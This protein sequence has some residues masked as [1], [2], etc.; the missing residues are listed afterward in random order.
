MASP[1]YLRV[2]SFRQLARSSVQ[3]TCR[4]IFQFA[5]A[6]T[7]VCSLFQ[8]TRAESQTAVTRVTQQSQSD[9]TR[10]RLPV[11]DGN[12]IRFSRLST[13]QGL[14]QTRVLQIVED[15]QGF[16]WLG[17]QY[18]LDRYDGYEY[19]VFVHDPARKNSLNCVYIH[20]LFKDRSG[21]L[22]VGCDSSL[23][24][25]DSLTET[26]AHYQITGAPG[27]T[28][29]AVDQ[30]SQD[31][32]GLLWL[33]TGKG[34]FGLNPNTGQIIHYGHDPSNS[35]SLGSNEVKSTMEDSSGRFWIIAGNNLEEFNRNS[36]RVLQRFRL[37]E[38]VR[39]S[40]LYEDHFGVIWV[41]YVTRGNKS[42]L[43]A[44][45]RATNRLSPYSLYD[46]R[47]GKGIYGGFFA[48]HEDKNKTLWFASFGA[49]LLK[50]DRE[51]KVFI[52]YRNHPGD[53]ESIAEDRVIS[54]CEDHE[55][56]L[57][58]GLHAREPNFFRIEHSPFIP[59]TRNQSNLNSF[60]ETFVNTIYED[61]EGVLWTGTTGALNRIDQPSGQSVSYLPPGQGF[62]NDIIAINEDASGA[63]WI[64]TF[65]GGLSRFDRR[66]G[67]YKTYLNEPGNP[68]SLSDNRVS[69]LFP[70]PDG[71]MW[72]ATWN[73]LDKFD[74][75]TDSFVTYKQDTTS[76]QEAYF[77]IT[78]DRAGFLW[79]GGWGSLKRFDPKTDQF[80]NFPY[81]AGDPNSLSDDESVNSVYIDHSG[82]VWAA[83]YNG[84]NKFNS[85]SGTFT[86]YFVKDGLPTNNLS[87]MLEDQSGMFWMSSS[88]GLSKF[89]PVA[90]KFTNYSTVDGL[91]GNDLTGWD[92]CFNSPSGEMFFG[93]F[94]GG[95]A[96]F[97]DKV[98]DKRD[99]L[100]LVLTDFRL[101][102]HPVEVG[103]RSPLQKSISYASD[104]TLTHD[105]NIFSLTFAALTYFNPDA[106]R[107]RYKLEH[108]EKNWTEVGSDRRVVTYTTLPAGIYIFHVQSATGQG[109]WGEPG[110]AIT[111]T[112]LPPWW[113]TTWFRLLSGVFILAAIGMLYK[114]RLQQLDRQFNA[115]LEGRVAERTRIARDL[116]D[117]LLQSFHGLMF[118]FQAARNMLPRSPEN[119]MRTLDEAIASTRAAITESR[120]AI[121]DLRSEPITHLDLAQLLEAEAE[122][123]AAV[124]D[125]HQS[126][127]AFRVIV[128]GEPQV[129]SSA[130]LDEVYR[131]ARE[132]VRNAF[133]HADATKVEAEIRYDKNQMRVRVRD[134]GKGLDPKALEVGQRPGHWGLAG[135]RE[136][137]QQIGAQLTVW[138][139]DGVGTE[140]ELT[141]ADIASKNAPNSSRF[142]L[143]RNERAS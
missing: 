9:T 36:G 110:L 54:L 122:G 51:Q 82:T 81:K 1:E 119:A 49:G 83:T 56:N 73:G 5:L 6:L 98:V 139:E 138:S 22:W 103:S 111:I 90:N 18:G 97:P 3:R 2:Q 118:R 113:A 21:T 33:S 67:K 89:D 15:N 60:G 64:G 136:R 53:L 7:T 50:F 72:I 70:N 96:F 108:L 105:Q 34:L 93:G 132:V 114:L 40:S 125:T 84:L 44:V 52:R 13:A 120:D 17:T 116:H 29:N 35:F 71:T 76:G 58:A 143:F 94:S 107:Y 65:G 117:T 133:R 134:N 20:S 129:I 130:L 28:V 86:H 10:V 31:R 43:A 137:A 46:Q 140:I 69:R 142:K 106:N 19:K 66:T 74:P 124:L 12:D 48:T 100:P 101:A 8:S 63:L 102:G 95:V 78:K 26:F 104:I 88:R 131:I 99:P 47:S 38:V 62:S 91:P 39:D 37:D 126:V 141:I 61:H 135:I 59:L 14:S 30:M 127:P 32:A 68:S 24:R 25:F 128:E 77:N 27:E 41:T 57:W 87:C 112:I 42:G 115:Q 45:D 79:M 55:G 123:L 16:I 80:T 11:V 4:R 23:D 92:A 109:S 75:K 121:H 85:E